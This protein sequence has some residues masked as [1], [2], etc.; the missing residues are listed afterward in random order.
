MADKM[1]RLAMI[2]LIRTGDAVLVS[3]LEMRLSEQGIKAFVLDDFTCSLYGGALDAIARRVMVDEA[4][5]PASRL[6]LAEAQRQG[7]AIA[8]DAGADDAGADDV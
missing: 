1:Q 5:L 7:V 4:D 3:W 8:G 2:E 6:I